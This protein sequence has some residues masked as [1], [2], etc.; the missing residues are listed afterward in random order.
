MTL[1]KISLYCILKIF[2]WAIVKE[3]SYILVLSYRDFYNAR[4]QLSP[5]LYC[6][7]YVLINL[8]LNLHQGATNDTVRTY[9]NKLRTNFLKL[10]TKKL[11]FGYF[12]LNESLQIK[13]TQRS[14]VKSILHMN[15]FRKIFRYSL[16]T[17]C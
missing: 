10:W 1:A 7:I 15:N 6:Y 2:T 16:V 3:I 12:V 11:I 5:N 13:F 8:L 14:L 4:K 9:C 17:H